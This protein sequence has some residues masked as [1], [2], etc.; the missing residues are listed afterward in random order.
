MA[1]V[2]RWNGYSALS[3]YSAGG[4]GYSAET[5]RIQCRCRVDTVRREVVTV[6]CGKWIETKDRLHNEDP[7]L[8]FYVSSKSS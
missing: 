7:S 2:L 3:G 5:R 6:Q 1:T 4:V 8:I